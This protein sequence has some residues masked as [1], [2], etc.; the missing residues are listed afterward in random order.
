MQCVGKKNTPLEPIKELADRCK[1]VVLVDFDAPTLKLLEA[2]IKRSNVTTRLVDLSGGA[3]KEQLRVGTDSIGEKSRDTYFIEKYISWLKAHSFTDKVSDLVSKILPNG[4]KADYVVSSLVA[5]EIG[6][7]SKKVVNYV[8]YNIFRIATFSIDPHYRTDLT[9]EWDRHDRMHLKVHLDLLLNLV[10]PTGK[11]YLAD[12][13]KEIREKEIAN[14]VHSKEAQEGV[15]GL[16]QQLTCSK[17]KSTWKWENGGKVFQ[18]D[19]WM[20]ENISASDYFISPRIVTGNASQAPTA[21]TIAAA[22]EPAAIEAN[23]PQP[24]AS[25]TL[26][27]DGKSQAVLK[28]KA[29]KNLENID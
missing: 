17:D 19:S 6:T 14:R 20:L 25:Q 23:K 28:G 24:P 27:E 18:V 3:Y 16:V 11:V 1:E 4:V 13:T 10:K 15:P 5:S 8:T 22:A 7:I 9:S 12:T 2:S 21:A 29:P 26:K